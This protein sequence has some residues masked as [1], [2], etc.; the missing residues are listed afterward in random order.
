[1]LGKEIFSVTSAQCVDVS[2]HV[3]QLIASVSEA[4]NEGPHD[5]A[6]LYDD[7]DFFDDV[8][9]HQL[10]HACNGKESSRSGNGPLLEHGCLQQSAPLRGSHQ[11]M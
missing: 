9:G 5:V 1:M 7:F 8:N 11:R 4:A 2:L 3:K 10:D 6:S